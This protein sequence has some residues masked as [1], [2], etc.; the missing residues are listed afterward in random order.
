ML[1][2]L[3]D[4]IYASLP[5]RGDFSTNP[6]LSSKVD[7]QGN[8]RPF[9]GN[10]TVFLLDDK[11]KQTL[12]SLQDGL[13][14]VA[15]PMLA[16]PLDPATFHMTL[17]DLVNGPKADADLLGRMG[18]AEQGA[19]ILLEA[20]KQEPK[21]AM[22]ATALFNMVNTSVAL[23][24][25]PANSRSMEQ[26]DKMYMALEQVVPLGYAMTPH[27]TLAYFKPGTYSQEQLQHLAGAL[28]SV[29]LEVE[30]NMENLVLQTFADMNHYENV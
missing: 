16:Q 25:A 11:T 21:I 29:Q 10:T 12:G 23:G 1:N 8:F 6:N 15:R 18:K 9:Y 24:L 27:I 17:H 2:L 26:L 13:Y 30:L 28:G 20:W 3:E 14:R 22:K 19:K 7:G 4:Y 5:R